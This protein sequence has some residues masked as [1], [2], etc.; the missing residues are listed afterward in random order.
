[1]IDSK[2]NLAKNATLIENSMD[3]MW[4]MW[5]VTLGSFSRTQ[6]QMENMARKQ[7]DQNKAAREEIIKVVENLSKQVRGNQTQLQKVIEESLSKT[8]TQMK[9]SNQNIMGDYAS[10]VV[11]LTSKA[12]NI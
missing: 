8:F 9:S 3:K 5:L 7:L 1:M 2:E 12:A 10:K 11:D 4:D 6:D